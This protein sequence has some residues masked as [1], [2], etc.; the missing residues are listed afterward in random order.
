ML[1][2]SGTSEELASSVR[3]G[4]TWSYKVSAHGLVSR[5]CSARQAAAPSGL[6]GGERGRRR[7]RGLRESG[8]KAIQVERGDVHLCLTSKWRIVWLR[9]GL[10]GLPAELSVDELGK[11]LMD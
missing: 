5:I 11:L 8:Q 2:P 9:Y 10:D 1:G 7:Q 3:G 4:L 6:E